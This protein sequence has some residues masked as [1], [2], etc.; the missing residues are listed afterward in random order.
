MS[1][2][3]RFVCGILFITWAMLHIYGVY[4]DIEHVQAL[5]RLYNRSKIWVDTEDLQKTEIIYVCP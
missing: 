5:T 3:F 1:N 2:I 4:Y